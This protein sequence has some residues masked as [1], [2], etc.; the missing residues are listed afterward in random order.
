MT[1]VLESTPACPFI[2]E[3]QD[4]RSLYFNSDGVQS[5]MLCQRPFDLTLPYTK[6]MMGFLLTN[7]HPAH[8]LM[9]GL[10]GGSMAKFCYQHLPH[11]RITVVEINPQVIALRQQFLVP[12]DDERFNVVCADGAHFVRDTALV[13]DV[14]L[15]DGFDAQGLAVELCSTC[16]YENCR[17]IMTPCGV[18]A[19]NLD[20][21]HTAHPLFIDRIDQTFQGNWVTIDVLERSN[22][23]AF[24]RKGL[25]ISPHEMSLS[26]SLGHHAVEA[27]AQLQTELQRI[28]TILDRQVPLE[29]VTSLTL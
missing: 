8:I 1:R 3:D 27:R 29:Q 25:P 26:D 17:R 24:A 2:H 23:I 14:V 16:F 6:T 19:A 13:F 7:A 10:G 28:L 11:T 4:S 22:C 20:N 18:L 12:D 5:K 9:I 21:V 15:V